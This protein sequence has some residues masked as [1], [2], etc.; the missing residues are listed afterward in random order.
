MNLETLKRFTKV[1]QDGHIILYEFEPC[2]TFYLIQSCNVKLVKLIGGIEKT[3]DVIGPSNVLGEMPILENSPLSESAIVFS[4]V[5]VL[6]FNRH[7]FEMLIQTN[8]NIRGAA[9]EFRFD[10]VI[11][12]KKF[13]A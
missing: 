7:N 8:L 9:L 2:Y 1:F 12:N 6:E 4:A 13:G 11:G 5:R 3:L 10:A